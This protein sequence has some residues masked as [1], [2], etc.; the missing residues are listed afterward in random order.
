M[1]DTEAV[2]GVPEQHGQRNVHLD[3]PQTG[4]PHLLRNQK[5][6]KTRKQMG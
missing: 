4:A 3:T 2:V 1:S 5:Q 6:Q